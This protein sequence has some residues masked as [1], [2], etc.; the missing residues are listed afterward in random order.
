MYAVIETGGKQYRVE[1]GSEIEVPHMELEPGQTVELGRV[2]MVADGEDASIGR[3][4][5]EGAMVSASVVRQDRGDKVVV[6]KYKPKA[7][8]RV[9]HGHRQDLTI[10]RIADIRLDGRS[11]AQ[12]AAAA[13]AERRAAEEAA[14]EEA[15]RR[16]EADKA[17]AAKLAAEADTEMAT[18]EQAPTTGKRRLRRPTVKSTAKDATMTTG[19]VARRTK[20]SSEKATTEGRAKGPTGAKTSGSRT[21]AGEAAETKKAPRAK[22]SAPDD[23]AEKDE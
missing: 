5:V 14:A 12:D 15:R 4:V 9:K 23:S 16:A 8:R 19:E 1:L 21:Q 18:D 20:S 11:A 17:L 22:K 7:R 3:P 6:F 13:E 2:L 10:L